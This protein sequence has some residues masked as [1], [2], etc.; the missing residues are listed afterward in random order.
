MLT[1]GDEASD[2]HGKGEDDSDGASKQEREQGRRE[3]VP[4]EGQK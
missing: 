3:G 1:R 2:A 4:D